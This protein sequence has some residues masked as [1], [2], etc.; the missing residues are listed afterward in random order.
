MT[1]RGHHAHWPVPAGKNAA[2]YLRLPLG[3]P[4]SMRDTKDTELRE[5]ARSAIAIV[6]T[7]LQDAVRQE[8][9]TLRSSVQAHLLALDR[10]LSHEHT[11]PTFEP[12]IDQLGAVIGARLNAIR[13]EHAQRLADV[14]AAAARAAAAQADAEREAAAARKESAALRNEADAVRQK[15]DAARQE[16]AAARKEADAARAAAA[17]AA[18]DLEKARKRIVA[19]EKAQEDLALERDI[20]NA[21]LEGEAHNRAVLAAELES[22]RA[23]SKQAKADVTALRLELK[24]AAP[25]AAPAAA[26]DVA[27]RLDQVRA[28]LELLIAASSAE[29]LFATGIELLADHF[30]RVAWCASGA[31]GLTMWQS[32]GFGRPQP[33]RK[34]P[35]TVAASS[36][37]ARALQSGQPATTQA[38]PGRT[39]RGLSES[40]A[41]YAIALPLVASDGLTM[42]LYAENPVDSP[43]RDTAA[44]EQVARIIADHIGYRLRRKQT[45]SPTGRLRPARA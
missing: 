14:E 1:L 26:A 22:A 13:S 30:G 17:S 2:R 36:P 5:H 6:T 21:H 43:G 8:L 9:D 32:Q 29:Q 42:I 24:R 20:A 41:S 27:G 25:A 44:A 11:K 39:V 38:P 28:A 45:A 18:A 12:I 10:V 40:P 15:G 35:I 33:G 23:Q 3:T 16:A 37:I 34:T 4:L 31:D 7:A 19:L